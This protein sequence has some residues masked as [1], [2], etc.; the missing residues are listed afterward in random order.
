MWRLV[1]WPVENKRDSILFWTIWR[2]PGRPPDDVTNFGSSDVT[3]VYLELHLSYEHYKNRWPLFSSVADK[4]PWWT[5]YGS[6]AVTSTQRPVLFSFGIQ[7]YIRHDDLYNWSWTTLDHTYTLRTTFDHTYTLRTTL[8]HTYTL[9]TTLDHTYTLR[10]TLDHTYTLR[11][12]PTPT[13]SGPHLTTPTLSG[14]HLTTPTLSGPHLTTPHTL[15]TTLDHTPHL[16]TTLDHT[17][18]LR[19]TLDPH[20]HSQDHT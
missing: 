15:R 20:L 7:G 5:S 10:T 19:T 2:H 13:L 11:T 4:I 12:T 9:R 16:R 8:D 6:P 3:F 17:Y 18:T 1:K 14:P